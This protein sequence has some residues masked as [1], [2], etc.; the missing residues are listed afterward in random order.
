MRALRVATRNITS[1]ESLI[2]SHHSRSNIICEFNGEKINDDDDD[3]DNTSDA[4][5]RNVLPSCANDA[6]GETLCLQ[7]EE[8]RY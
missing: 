7:R 6:E 8:E 2:L 5:D 3:D 1:L 4:D